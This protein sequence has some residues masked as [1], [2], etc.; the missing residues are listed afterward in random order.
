MIATILKHCAC[1]ERRGHFGRFVLLAIVA[2]G[3]FGALHDQISY[4]VSHEYYT[5][6]KFTQFGLDDIELPD[7]VK[8]SIVGF[9]A[10]WWMGLL[11]GVLTGAAAYLYE[12]P[13]Q[14]R[15]AL[16][17]SIPPAIA[18]ALSVALLGLAL[19]WLLT[20]VWKSS[21]LNVFLPNNLD[22]P[23]DFFCAACMHSAAYLGGA[24]AVPTLWY[25]HYR[26]SRVANTSPNVPA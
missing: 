6:L 1:P 5:K 8:A 20:A 15:R 19:S 10:T 22:A 9:L 17:W 7:R 16:L 12:T 25:A 4:T 26:R 21:N 24:L 18:L 11:L 14:M 23:R 13:E 2:A 3:L